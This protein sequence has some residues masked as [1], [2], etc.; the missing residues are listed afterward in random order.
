MLGEHWEHAGVQWVCGASSSVHCVCHITV[1]SLET[2]PVTILILQSGK[3]GPSIS[4]SRHNSRNGCF[5]VSICSRSELRTDGAR[6]D[7]SGRFRTQSW[8]KMPNIPRTSVERG[9]VTLPHLLTCTLHVW[10]TLA[11]SMPASVYINNHVHILPPCAPRPGEGSCF[12][13]LDEP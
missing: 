12:S 6:R 9:G 4:T 13:S 1:S 11:N 5:S 3:L 10:P 7:T 2:S 8:F